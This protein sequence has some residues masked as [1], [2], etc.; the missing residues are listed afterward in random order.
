[1]A[2][3]APNSLCI[4]YGLITLHGLDFGIPAEMTGLRHLPITTSK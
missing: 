4:F 2:T 1:M 3:D